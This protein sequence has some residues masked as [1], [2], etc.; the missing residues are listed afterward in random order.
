MRTLRLASLIL[1]VACRA[2]SS[3]PACEPDDIREAAIRVG[4]LWSTTTAKAIL[5]SARPRFFSIF[6]DDPR[7]VTLTSDHHTAERSVCDCCL[8][9]LFERRETSPALHRM[10]V[11][12]VFNSKE[13]AIKT[14]SLL[15]DAIEGGIAR[16]GWTVS[17]KVEVRTNVWDD[18]DGLAVRSMEI[19]IVPDRSTWRMLLN[20]DRNELRR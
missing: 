19:R 8:I 12:L 3:P 6:A 14:A 20:T 11:N 13:E 10:T 18:P 5:E 15:G 1:F 9:L 17:D 2:A 4:K 7:F 16:S